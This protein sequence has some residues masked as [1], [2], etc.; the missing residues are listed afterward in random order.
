[1][2]PGYQITSGGMQTWNEIL[3]DQNAKFPT[4]SKKKMTIIITV[5]VTLN[6]R[7]N[8]KSYFS[9]SSIISGRLLSTVFSSTAPWAPYSIAVLLQA[10]SSSFETVILGGASSGICLFLVL[11][12]HSG[13][14]F[15][16]SSSLESCRELDFSLL[17]VLELLP[18]TRW[19]YSSRSSCLYSGAFVSAGG[20]LD[21]I[22]SRGRCLFAELML[23]LF[24]PPGAFPSC[25]GSP[26][27][28]SLKRES[29]SSVNP[30]QED[31]MRRKIMRRCNSQL[32][33][34]I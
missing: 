11:L 17:F 12:S 6:I 5:T 1:M 26:A 29:S 22:F 34:F 3:Y 32:R 9:F 2:Y 21:R 30:A 18:W 16:L 14:E 13:E 23:A 7:L 8:K 33:Y 15:S 28:W 24:R 19:W 10:S 20:A 27:V 25:P 31:I 4:K